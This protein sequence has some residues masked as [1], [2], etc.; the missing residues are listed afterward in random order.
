[1]IAIDYDSQTFKMVK[2]SLIRSMS[3]HNL[4]CDSAWNETTVFK[5]H[6]LARGELV[7]QLNMASPKV[8]SPS[9]SVTD[10]H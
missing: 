4:T 1:M 2:F 6:S 9:I 10:G 8:F 3:I 7:L 5:P